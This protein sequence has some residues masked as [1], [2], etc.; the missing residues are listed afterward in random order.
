MGVT[1]ERDAQRLTQDSRKPPEST[2]TMSAILGVTEPITEKY[3]N[4]G[5]IPD[6]YK[7]AS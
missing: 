5:T 7:I 3:R 2:E 4:T 1:L 6:K